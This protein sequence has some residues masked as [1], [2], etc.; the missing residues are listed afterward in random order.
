[1]IYVTVILKYGQTSQCCWPTLSVFAPHIRLW[2]VDFVM[3]INFIIVPYCHFP[4]SEL[5]PIKQCCKCFIHC[6]LMSGLLMLYVRVSSWLTRPT[7]TYFKWLVSQRT[8]SLT[9]NNDD[10]HCQQT[11]NGLVSRECQ[12]SVKWKK[13]FY[14]FFEVYISEKLTVL[15]PIN[16]VVTSKHIKTI[17]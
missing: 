12:P 14:V 15:L 13:K 7:V 9:N 17:T 3:F 16:N 1:M 6:M 4:W 11:M 5:S 8:L 2:Q 10:R